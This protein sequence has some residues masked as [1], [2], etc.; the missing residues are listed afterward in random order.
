MNKEQCMIF[1]N[2]CTLVLLH[3]ITQATPLPP[4]HLTVKLVLEP[5][6]DGVGSEEDLQP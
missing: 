4:F 3:N 5:V 1:I 6:H 2:S